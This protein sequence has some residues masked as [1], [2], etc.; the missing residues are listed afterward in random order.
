[1]SK[2]VYK[3]STLGEIP[4]SFTGR[5]LLQN[6]REAVQKLLSEREEELRKDPSAWRNTEYWKEVSLARGKLAEY[7]SKLEEKTERRKE[8]INK[9]FGE[10][11][12]KPAK[13]QVI[14]I[15]LPPIPEGYCLR[16][17]GSLIEIA[18]IQE[19]SI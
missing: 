14:N 7:M 16:V 6:L 19:T 2:E 11:Q 18:P 13:G 12:A 17:V 10:A 8:I 4:L 9:Q 5:H 15:Q 3:S 1:M